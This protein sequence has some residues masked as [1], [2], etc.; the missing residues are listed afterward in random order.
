MCAKTERNKRDEGYYEAKGPGHIISLIVILS[1]FLIH[2]L[3]HCKHRKRL[4]QQEYEMYEHFENQKQKEKQFHNKNNNEITKT[5]SNTN[6][7]TNTNT[8]SITTMTMT[9]TET[10]FKTPQSSKTTHNDKN[11][12]KSKKDAI[13]RVWQQ[14]YGKH[15]KIEAYRCYESQWYKHSNRVSV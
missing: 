8:E 3:V 10:S 13:F 5:T 4:L 1:L 12:I 7:D 11:K 2:I 14:K 6:I 15:S 9:M